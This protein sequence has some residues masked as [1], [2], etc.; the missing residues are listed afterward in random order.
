MN[1]TMPPIAPKIKDSIVF[2]STCSLTD[3][4][5]VVERG[6]AVLAFGHGTQTVGGLVHGTGEAVGDN[7]GVAQFA[8]DG[9][10]GSPIDLPPK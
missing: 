2:E 9:E 5:G 4:K 6:A 3:V 7:V 8:R 1:I 10:H